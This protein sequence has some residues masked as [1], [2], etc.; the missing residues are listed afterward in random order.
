MLIGAY[1]L[2]ISRSYLVID[3]PNLH[4]STDTFL[5]DQIPVQQQISTH[6]QVQFEWTSSIEQ[7]IETNTHKVFVNPTELV[8]PL[9]VRRWKAGDYFYPLGLGKKKKL[10]KF[11]ADKKLN[12]AEKENIWIVESNKKIIWVVGYC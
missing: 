4:P 6:E 12:L 7:E 5:I 11:F 1:R 2:F 3:K 9:C 10:K 8:F